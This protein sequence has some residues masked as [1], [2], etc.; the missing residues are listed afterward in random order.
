MVGEAALLRRPR[1]CWLPLAALTLLSGCSAVGTLAAPALLPRWPLVVVALSPRWPYLVLAARRSGFLPFLVIAVARLA[2]ADPFHYMLGTHGRAALA[3]RRPTLGRAAA[4]AAE[5]VRRGGLLAVGLRPSGLVL[6][7]AGGAGVPAKRV[8]AA[9]LI[10]TSI[11]VAGLYAASTSIGGWHLPTPS[12][13]LLAA[14]A[15][16]AAVAATV[17]AA[18]T[19]RVR[20][21]LGSAGTS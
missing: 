14:T 20:A 7:A 13:W 12:C 18:V 8:A 2:V 10:G 19:V 9:D 4:R 11:Q 3:R 17:G 21:G 15:S 1:H 5:V 6:A 16:G